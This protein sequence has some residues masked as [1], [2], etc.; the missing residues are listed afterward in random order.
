VQF[1]NGHIHIGQAAEIDADGRTARRGLR[2]GSQPQVLGGLF[3]LRQVFGQAG[4]IGN[5]LH[6]F[7]LAPAEGTGDVA[8]QE[9]PQGFEF[10]DCAAG[11][12]EQFPLRNLILFRQYGTGE[13]AR[14]RL[15]VY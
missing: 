12:Q 2:T 7:Q 4:T 14:R 9:A 1:V 3:R 5:G 6:L 10:Q 11:L 15:Q 8:A 13:I